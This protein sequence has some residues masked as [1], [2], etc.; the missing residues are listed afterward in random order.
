M[1]D[2]ALKPLFITRLSYFVQFQLSARFTEPLPQLV[3]EANE[4]WARNPKSGGKQDVPRASRLTNPS[5][6]KDNEFEIQLKNCEQNENEAQDS[7]SVL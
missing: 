1:T 7:P 3:R 2:E 4:N 5:A 6:C